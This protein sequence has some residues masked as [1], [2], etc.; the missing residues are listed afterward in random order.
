MLCVKGDAPYT[1]SETDDKRLV[2]LIRR[3][4]CREQQHA[5]GVRPIST[6][7]RVTRLCFLPCPSLVVLG[8]RAA[9]R[10]RYAANVSVS[11]VALP[12]RRPCTAPALSRQVRVCA[13][14]TNWID[15]HF[16]GL[17]D[18]AE[19]VDPYTNYEH[20]RA[21]CTI[22]FHPHMFAPVSP[23][24][25]TKSGAVWKASTRSLVMTSRVSTLQVKLLDS[26]IL[27]RLTILISFVTFFLNTQISCA[28]DYL[29]KD[30]YNIRVSYLHTYIVIVKFYFVSSNY[31]GYEVC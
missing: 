9:T 20:A 4:N 18:L 16:K 2:Q 25:S 21:Q 28:I 15:L 12:P 6:G 8:I 31:I 17:Q 13:L 19:G 29:N 22:K 3:S 1:F 23:K 10:L 24:G 7:Y 26:L 27:Y 14:I 30:F 11:G 5:R